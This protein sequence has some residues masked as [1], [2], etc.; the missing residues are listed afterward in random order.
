[1][2]STPQFSVNPPDGTAT[3]TANG[4]TPPY[5]FLWSN[6]QSSTNNP[7][8]ISDLANGTY[9]VIISDANG[10]T[11]TR[12][13]AVLLSGISSLNADAYSTKLYPNPT[14]NTV[15]V[16]F[17]AENNENLNVRMLN[18]NGQDVLEPTR[19]PSK[20]KNIITLDVSSLPRGAYFM[21]ITGDS[22]TASR[23]LIKL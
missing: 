15:T 12:T 5:S 23:K 21:Q 8:T 3:I 13:F 4:G 19:I 17:N 6:G 11:L 7:S 22:G 14:S 16:E 1:V 2:S 20:G 18:L 10:C 9:N